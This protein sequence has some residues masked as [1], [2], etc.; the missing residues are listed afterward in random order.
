MHDVLLS[1]VGF[2]GDVVQSS[3]EDS[4]CGRLELCKKIKIEAYDRDI[5]DGLLELGSMYLTVREFV[6]QTQRSSS[7]SLYDLVLA[8]TLDEQILLPYEEEIIVFEK[9]I[10][11]L[12]ISL[13]A[14]RLDLWDRFY[15]GFMILTSEVLASTA[16]R[17]IDSIIELY[18][19]VRHPYVELLLKALI[20]AFCQELISWC[21]YGLVP[22]GPTRT[23]FLVREEVVEHVK[24]RVDDIAVFKI[25]RLRIPSRLV[26]LETCDKML[27]CG[28]AVLVLQD[29]DRSKKVIE[30]D[31]EFFA[32][33]IPSD[34]VLAG[35]F[36]ASEIERMRTSLS[37]ALSQRLKTNTEPNLRKCLETVRELFLLGAASQWT[38][39]IEQINSPDKLDTIFKKLF[40]CSVASMT[41]ERELMVD[42]PWPMDL[43]IS[44]AAI[45]EYRKIFD[46]MYSVMVASVRV[47]YCYNMQLTNLI[48]SL[49]AYFQLDVVECS[50][51]RLM[52]VVDKS[53]DIQKIAEAHDHFLSEIS[54]GCLVD[55]SSVWQHI[56]KLFGL[57]EELANNRHLETVI[58]SQVSAEMQLLIQALT[59]LRDRPTHKSVEKLLLKVDFNNFYR[60]GNST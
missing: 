6:D 60:S 30:K 4:A 38:C 40:D 53:D 31:F 34:Y 11:E 54:T 27:F 35:D 33:E 12:G 43:V 22:G 37:T 8:K 9:K 50:F 45:D 55:I 15:Q 3:L 26:S 41:E 16:D 1:L 36:I 48:A 14:L 46:V 56:D 32:K 21:R 18:D 17:S 13:S 57:G 29:G 20:K 24:S 2:T 39:F 44:A 42:F 51:V 19:R 52:N 23:Q 59:D 5:V 7:A 10:L 58:N 49:H 25:D 47:R 28:R